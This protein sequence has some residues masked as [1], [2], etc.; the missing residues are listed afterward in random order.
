M[1]AML[2]LRGRH[3]VPDATVRDA[4]TN[5][6]RWSFDIRFIGAIR[7]RADQVPLSGGRRRSDGGSCRSRW[8][9]PVLRAP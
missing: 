9:P 6:D 8:P 4:R 5:P 7:L 2:R 1:W 3:A